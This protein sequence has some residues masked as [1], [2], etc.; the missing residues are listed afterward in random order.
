[1]QDFDRLT[2]QPLLLRPG[3]Q[4]QVCHQAGTAPAIVFLHGGLG[5]RFNLRSQ[6]EFAVDQGWQALVYDLAGHGESS[7]YSRYSI[8]RHGRDLTRLLRHFQIKRPILLAHSYGVPLALEWCQ[9]HPVTG[10]V[11]VAGGTH[12][13]DPWWEVPL[14][15]S[16]AWGGRH[17]FRWDWLQRQ[18]AQASSRHNHAQIQQFMAESPVPV[19]QSPYEALRVFWGYDFFARRRQDW[20]LNY[21]ALIISGGQD[22]MFTQAMGQALTA[23]FPHG[24][25]L[26][27]ENA[28][29]L[30]MAEYPDQ[31]NAELARFR[32]HC[33]G[34]LPE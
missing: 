2:G 7:P 29:H 25:H 23:H 24:Q 33:Y 3:V 32:N 8:G 17:L 12:D 15:Q 34:F 19:E 26:H 28:G 10:L 27:L 21:P 22:P 18:V 11:L 6:Y 4:L 14:M 9:H 20:Q 1:M 30:I 16:L 31:I 13:L 5:N